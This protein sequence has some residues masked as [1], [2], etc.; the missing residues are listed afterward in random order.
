MLA[1]AIRQYKEK[2]R[3]AYWEGRNKLPLYAD[4]IIVY[5]ENMK[6]LKKYLEVINNYSK[7]VGYNTNT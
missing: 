2:K 5:A 6:E 1:N 4:D 7:I 3:Y